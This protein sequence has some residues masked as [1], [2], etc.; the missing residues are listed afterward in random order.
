MKAP[1]GTPRYWL[2]LIGFTLI[3]SIIGYFAYVYIGI[4]YFMAKGYTHPQRMPLCC[5]NPSDWG[6][7]YEDVN[8]KTKDGIALRGWYIPSQNKAAIILL[9]P[10]ASNRLGTKDLAIMFAR[11]GY[12]ILMIDLRA[13]GESEGDILTYGGDEF[14]DV[15]AGVDY[16]QSR[17]EVDPDKLGVMG[18]SLGASTSILSAARDERL[19]AVVAN[20][21]GA[22]VF[23][24]WPKPDTIY[25]SFYV[26]FDLMFFFYLHR[27]DGVAKPLAILDAVKKISPRPLF[28]IDETS[29]GST[30]GPRSI[31]QFYAAANEP[32]EMWTI[33]NTKHISGL[34][35][36]PQEYEK[37]VIGFFDRYLL[38]IKDETQ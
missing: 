29:D 37:K 4:S 10:I 13:H 35:T 15:S 6:L 1:R 34:Y 22:V 33:P 12:G 14:L 19:A 20:A 9:H 36:H 23:E 11:Y 8:L 27:I 30:L 18:L 16:L 3:A 7:D 24:D 2:N 26:P 25:D 32:K 5:D 38:D 21:P 17:P 28:L 31:T